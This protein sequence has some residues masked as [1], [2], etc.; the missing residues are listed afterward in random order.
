MTEEYDAIVVGANVAGSSASY[1]L[2]KQGFEVLVVELLP[3]NE[4][5]SISCGDG[6]DVH[7]FK[8]LGLDVPT[9]EFVYGDVIRGEV[10]A[11]NGK[12]KLSAQGKIKAVHRYRF[13]QYLKERAVDAGAD[14]VSP[15][16]AIAP[17]IQNDQVVGLRYRKIKIKPDKSKT[18]GEIE[19][20]K[21]KVLVD[22]S[23]LNA[24]IRSQLPSDWWVTEKVEP[25]DIA[26]CYK[27]SRV[28]AKPLPHKFIHG[29]FSS[30]IAP[31]GFYWLATRSNTLIN[32]GLGI[33]MK[34]QPL[35]P[36]KQLYNEILPRHDFL[37]ESTIKWKGGGMVPRRWPLECM[38]GNGFVAAGDA[39]AM[40]NPM[41][42]GGIGP[43][44]FAGKLAG[45]IIPQAMSVGKCSLE[46]LWDYNY[47]YNTIYGPVQA[48]NYILR[49]TIE[50][51]T[52]EQINALLGAE[53]FTET[54]IIEV[55]ESGKLDLGFTN[56]LKKFGKL[57]KHPKL[58]MKLRSLY[59]NMETARK[60]YRDYPENIANFL[61]WR[62]KV[63]RFFNKI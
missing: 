37:K 25:S 40:V 50:D 10:I 45:K 53:L 54:E 33:N 35:S 23:G 3:S 36:K 38:V 62:T 13:C 1:N 11:P 46:A 61:P 58:L 63:R 29:Y 42:G 7:E 4:I 52:D 5:G 8:R 18:A 55:I 30:K 48:G 59:K 24:V 12:A 22:A 20:Q 49:R 9:G 60:L 56:K 43:S 14:L 51:L 32:V 26:V 39:A 16:R 34:Y 27:E 2:T 47:E 31:G 28:F 6:L 19:S 44:V 57:A 21:C 15:A 17:V 41:S